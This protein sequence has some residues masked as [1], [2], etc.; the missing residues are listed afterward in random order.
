[1]CGFILFSPLSVAAIHCASA[2]YCVVH[3]VSVNSR[4]PICLFANVCTFDELFSMHQC[5]HIWQKFFLYTNVCTFDKKFFRTPMFAH[6]TKVFLC[7]NV[8][9]FDE[10]LLRS[11][12]HRQNCKFSTPPNTETISHFQC[13]LTGNKPQMKSRQYINFKYWFWN[14]RSCPVLPRGQ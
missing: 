3:F 4:Q 2:V 10:S 8:C 9:T 1:M 5:L 6:L 14:S 13:L 11:T 12:Y 7:T